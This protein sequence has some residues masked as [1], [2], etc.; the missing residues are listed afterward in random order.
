MDYKITFNKSGVIKVFYCSSDSKSEALEI[1][2]SEMHRLL[3]I[4]F[5]VIS[6]K[7]LT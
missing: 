4:D 5:P 6:I 2:H 3:G 1:F 7:E